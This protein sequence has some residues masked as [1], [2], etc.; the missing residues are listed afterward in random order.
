MPRSVWQCALLADRFLT[1]S[2]RA[3]AV[4]GRYH[5]PRVTAEHLCFYVF[6][7]D[8]M[9]ELQYEPRGANGRRFLGLF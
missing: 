1:R 8:S 4:T 5:A 2:Q 3:M 9:A 7:K 6:S